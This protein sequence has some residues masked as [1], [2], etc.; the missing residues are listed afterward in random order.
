M[1]TLNPC[2]LY[3]AEDLEQKGI[4]RYRIQE[5]SQ[6][7]LLGRFL[8]NGSFYGGF[9]LNTDARLNLPKREK[10]FTPEELPALEQLI[11]PVEQVAN[12][13]GVSIEE[14]LSRRR[15]G[16]SIVQEFTNAQGAEYL[17]VRVN[18]LHYIASKAVVPSRLSTLV[19]QY[20]KTK[21]SEDLNTVLKEGSS[22]VRVAAKRMK[23][24][25]PPQITVDDL[26]SAGY[27]GLLESVQKY[28]SKENVPFEHYARDFVN[29]R[30]RDYLR[31][32]QTI[33][34]FCREK[35]DKI[36]IATRQQYEV[37]DAPPTLE[38]VQNSTQLSSEQ[39]HRAL[40]NSRLF[41]L[42]SLNRKVKGTEETSCPLYT[43]LPSRE[44][45][46]ADSVLREDSLNAFWDYVQQQCDWR[47]R[48]L[49]YNYFQEGISLKEAGKLLRVSE[50]RARQLLS[51]ILKRVRGSER[52]RKLAFQ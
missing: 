18:I 27:D 37:H 7:K 8:A 41:S 40:L 24:I 1:L 14:L 23:C 50:S 25:V 13:T 42:Q 21:T 34:R 4:T 51:E 9:V 15:K 33:S 30:M 48:V 32:Q 46:P 43:L 3:S 31:T 36:E 29:N 20:E 52:A 35:C 11:V 49:L 19:L 17:G 39:I 45:S 44:E 12:V 10:I 5:F 22:F 2:E 38:E 16:K 26:V 47:E 28:S 6:D